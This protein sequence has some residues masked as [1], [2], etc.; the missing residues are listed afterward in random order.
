MCCVC[1]NLSAIQDREICCY[2]ISCKEKENIGR[3]SVLVCSHLPLYRDI[4]RCLHLEIQTKLSKSWAHNSRACI[5][6]Q[7]SCLEWKL[8]KIIFSRDL[9][10]TNMH[11][12]IKHIILYV[13]MVAI[14][15]VKMS[16]TI[17]VVTPWWLV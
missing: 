16:K 6:C 5:R 1:R 8:S 11:I 13:I 4:I 3:Y 10:I 12:K 17:E 9:I 14:M 2:S 7:S 15:N